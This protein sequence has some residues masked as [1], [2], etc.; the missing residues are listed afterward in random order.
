MNKGAKKN[1]E[2]ERV[3]K[4]ATGEEQGGPGPLHTGLCQLLTSC[5]AKEKRVYLGS[6]GLIPYKQKFQG[7]LK[8]FYFNMICKSGM[9]EL[10]TCSKM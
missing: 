10:K 5:T 8:E 6:V 2:E 1:K 3:E 7:K 4:L 9:C